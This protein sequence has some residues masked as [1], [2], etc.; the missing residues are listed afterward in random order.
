ML[1][2]SALMSFPAQLSTTLPITCRWRHT[3]FNLG[4]THKVSP[5]W[6]LVHHSTKL[7]LHWLLQQEVKKKKKKSDRKRKGLWVM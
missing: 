3:H 2:H 1:K 5:H 4:P 7:K 6:L